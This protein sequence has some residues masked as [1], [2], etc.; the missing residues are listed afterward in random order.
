MRGSGLAVV[1][2]RHAGIPD[3][4]LENET[5][6]LVDERDVEGMAQCALRMAREPQLAA[7]MGRAARVRIKSEFSEERSFARLWTIIESAVAEREQERANLA[8]PASS[9]S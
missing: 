5:G 6:L 1:S 8:V 9:L 2:T 7:R 4:V 3:V